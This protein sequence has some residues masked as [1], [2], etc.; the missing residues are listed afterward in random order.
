MQ[1]PFSEELNVAMLNSIGA[2]YMVTKES[3]ASGGFEEKVNACLKTGC[4]CIVIKKPDEDGI[5]LEELKILIE[6]DLK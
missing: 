6:K 2:K 5:S 3:A 1:G 4:K